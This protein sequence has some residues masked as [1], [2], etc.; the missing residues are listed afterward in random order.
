MIITLA[1]PRPAQIS[2]A[3]LRARRN[4]GSPSMGMVLTMIIV[5]DERTTRTPCRP[6]RRPAGSTRPASCW[7]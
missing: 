7:W 4:A 2:A 3:L 5:C 1:T 6:A